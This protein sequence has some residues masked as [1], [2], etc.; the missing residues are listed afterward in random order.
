MPKK[1]T[2]AY[3]NRHHNRGDEVYYWPDGRN[4][5]PILTRLRSDAWDTQLGPV[6]L[7]FATAGGVPL[8][9]VEHADTVGVPGDVSE[10]VYPA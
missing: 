5:P 2:A 3:W 9:C 4:R 7:V 8:D 10:S 1:I 6:V